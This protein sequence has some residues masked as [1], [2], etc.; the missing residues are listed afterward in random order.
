[1][2]KN[3]IICRTD[4]FSKALAVLVATY[5]NFNI[6]YPA[7]AAAVLQLIQLYFYKLDV[8]IESKVK[9]SGKH[10]KR[11]ILNVVSKFITSCLPVQVAQD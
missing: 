5:F 9:R 1:M 11:G 6:A 7:G 4:T 3:N 2:F 8:N 10:A